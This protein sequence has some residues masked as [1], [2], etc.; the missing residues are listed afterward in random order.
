MGMWLL[1]RAGGSLRCCLAWSGCSLWL[2]SSSQA[3]TIWFKWLHTISCHMLFIITLTATCSAH[4][5]PMLSCPASRH[6]PP[7]QHIWKIFIYS[8]RGWGEVV[9]PNWTILWFNR[10]LKLSG[11]FLVTPEIP[12]SSHT[13]A[14][15]AGIFFPSMSQ[16]QVGRP[17]GPR[18]ANSMWTAIS[19]FPVW[20]SK[21]LCSNLKQVQGTV[22]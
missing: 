9:I 10:V 4:A 13:A 15:P 1:P 6:I 12:P 8:W 21:Q 7:S 11:S 5:A 3:V 20:R 18:I 16:S 22:F 17:A 14:F 19:C 2:P